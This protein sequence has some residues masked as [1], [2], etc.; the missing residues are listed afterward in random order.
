MTIREH[1]KTR[2]R[3]L[4]EKINGVIAEYEEETGLFV[5]EIKLSYP[6]PP[7]TDF[8]EVYLRVSV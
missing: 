1:N 8:T 3:M 2:K 4:E 5:M 7:F 6:D